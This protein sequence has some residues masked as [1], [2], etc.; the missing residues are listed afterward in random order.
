MTDGELF[1]EFTRRVQ[2]A[3]YDNLHVSVYKHTGIPFRITWD[4]E[5]FSFDPAEA[6]REGLAP[7]V[8]RAI[9][10]IRLSRQ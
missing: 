4:H 7:C 3:V 5:F 2:D 6:R 1:H 9:A 8:D 10:R